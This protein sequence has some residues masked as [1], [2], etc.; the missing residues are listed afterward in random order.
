MDH[1]KHLSKIKS[2]E[3]GPQGTVTINYEIIYYI[4]FVDMPFIKLCLLQTTL[5]KK[6]KKMSLVL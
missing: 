5:L 3:I 2:L 6:E 4:D 1:S